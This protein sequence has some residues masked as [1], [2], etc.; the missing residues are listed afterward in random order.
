M[1][2]LSIITVC[3]NSGD[4]IERTIRS[5]LSQKNEEIE[6]IIIDGKSTDNTLEII[7]K[8]KQD[9]D[10]FI[11]EKDN[12]ISDAFNK[13]IKVSRG[14][15]IGIINA[16]DQYLPGA[17]NI[18]LNNAQEEA[19]VFFGN[20]IRAYSD[21]QFRKYMA[22]PNVDGLHD[23]MTLVHPSTFVRK[24]V[25]DHFGMFDVNYRYVMD[26][27]LL[28]RFLNKGVQFQYFNVYLA[29]YQMGGVSDHGYLQGVVP[30]SY[31]LDLFDGRP[32]Y[33]AFL[34]KAKRI[35]WF[36]FFKLRRKTSR[37][38]YYSSIDEILNE[39]IE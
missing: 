27:E 14:E 16:D 32:K 18:L 30:E 24:S 25:Y 33:M 26:R 9:I 21:T 17:F 7:Y 8:Y 20:G 2:R 12:G 39:A 6:Y 3:F 22:D 10:Y 36:M 11:S 37:Q 28:L 5:V 35:L 15:W 1:I 31:Q 4:T 34:N 23:S 13:G 19:G 29:V 38:K